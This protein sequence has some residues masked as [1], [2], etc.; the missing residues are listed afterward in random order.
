MAGQQ[1][2]RASA[3]LM[4][5]GGKGKV[6]IEH[7]ATGKM[8]DAGNV[9]SYSLSLETDS[10]TYE[11][12]EDDTGIPLITKFR[13][14]AAT[15][16]LT[17]RSHSLIAKILGT[18][19]DEETYTQAQAQ[20]Q[21]R[22]FLGDLFVGRI[23]DLD[24]Y[25]VTLT[26]VAGQAGPSFTTGAAGTLK[27]WV[28]GT[29]FRINDDT[30]IMKIIAQPAGYVTT[31]PT[32]ETEIEFDQAA[33]SESQFGGYQNAQGALCRIVLID[34]N[35][36]GPRSKLVVHRVRIIKDGEENRIT[37]GTDPVTIAFTGAMEQDSTQP[38]GHEYYTETL[39]GP[40][41]A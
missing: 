11:T 13:I 34:T 3:D 25:N 1:I 22:T 16:A 32:E 40:L 39:L 30:G 38:T 29:H 21:T 24:A 6:L 12:S 4:K 23:L 19:S 15:I 27:T 35:T 14:T 33:F 10:A 7:L 5:L 41:A 37:D 9:E 26:T 18:M 31:G 2:G 8:Y 28:Q 36:S 20:G 17:V